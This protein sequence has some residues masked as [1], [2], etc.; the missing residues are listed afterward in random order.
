MTSTKKF[1]S[2][3]KNLTRLFALS[4][5]SGAIIWSCGGNIGSVFDPDSPCATV[6]EDQCGTP[7][8]DDGACGPGLYCNEGQCF[9]DCVAGDDRCDVGECSESGR[10]IGTGGSSSSFDPVGSGGAGG[11]GTGA[12]G[13]CGELALELEATIPTVVLLIDQ[14]GSMNQDFNGQGERWDVVY[15]ALMNPTDGVVK[16]L[17]EYVRFGLALYTYDRNQGG[18]CPHIVDVLP[19]ALDNHANIDGV[20]SLESYIADTPTGDAITAIT[21]DLDN[22]PEPGPKLIVLATDGEPD[23]CEDPD[24]HGQASKDEATDAAAAAYALGIETVIIA[25]GDGVSQSHQQDMANAG[26]GRPVPAPDPCDQVNDPMN[27]APTYEPSTKQDLIDTFTSVILSQRDCVFT[28]NG[29]VIQG[30]ECDGTVTLNG[31]ELP[32]NDPDGWHLNGTSEIEF[33]G[34][35]C[36]LILNELDVVINASFPC[37]SILNPPE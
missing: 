19:P 29:D 2:G 11:S 20:Y 23:R 26:S 17:E 30:K 22:F 24:D 28:L 16:S 5:V 34:A 36:E 10:C 12:G 18:M 4:A 7:C 37:E 13:A 25:V 15:D 31:V 1:H 3:R 27:C 14:S 21:P 6:Y 35:A 8:K 33:D 9:A 32:C